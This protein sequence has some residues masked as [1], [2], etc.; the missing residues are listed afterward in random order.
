MFCPI[1]IVSDARLEF[2]YL[3]LGS[4]QLIRKFLSDLSCCLEVCLSRARGAVNQPKK[5]ISCPVQYIGF[6]IF[7]IRSNVRN[8]GSPRISNLANGLRRICVLTSH[9]TPRLPQSR[10]IS[11]SQSELNF[12]EFDPAVDNLLWTQLWQFGDI[13]CDPPRLIFGVHLAVENT[14][15]LGCNTSNNSIGPHEVDLC[16]TDAG[17]DNLWITFE[18]EIDLH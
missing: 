2:I 16:A 10:N 14:A 1:S 12:G 3:A 9:R 13:R 17:V 5:G 4:S 18:R 6:S 15:L 7:C 8:N 11:A